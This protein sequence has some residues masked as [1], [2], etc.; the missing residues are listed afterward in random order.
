MSSEPR[1]AQCRWWSEI[2]AAKK[3]A[4]PKIDVKD[5]SKDGLAEIVDLKLLL[6]RGRDLDDHKRLVKPVVKDFKT[7]Y[8]ASK[9]VAVLKEAHSDLDTN[10][11]RIASILKHYGDTR[12]Y[13][14]DEHGA[15]LLFKDFHRYLTSNQDCSPLM[16]FE[17]DFA[18]RQDS[19]GF[20]G[21]L[22]QYDVPEYFNGDSLFDGVPNRPPWRWLIVAPKRSGTDLHVDPLSTSAWNTLIEGYK[23][24][25]ILPPNTTHYDLTKQTKLFASQWFTTIGLKSAQSLPPSHRPKII[26]QRPGETIFVPA[27]RYHVVVNLTAT[28]AITENFAVRAHFGDVWATAVLKEPEFCKEWYRHLSQVQ[29]ELA[30]RAGG[31]PEGIDSGVDVVET[32]AES[33]SDDSGFDLL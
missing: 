28:V 11:Y 5:W 20:K 1:P 12:F 2:N 21:G 15:S 3:R 22:A 31:L 13:L 32:A 27:G 26:L 29:P 33:Q 19:K 23:L 9:R 6:K 14:D 7:R 10:R 24:W 30:K 8:I 17:C 18:D 16:I 4:R 25:A